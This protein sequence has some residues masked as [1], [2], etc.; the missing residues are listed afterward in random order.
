MLTE[1]ALRVKLESFRNQDNTAEPFHIFILTRSRRAVKQKG[2][3]CMEKKIFGIIYLLIDCTNDF[4]YVG[5]TTRTFEARFNQHKSGKQY[6]DRIIRERGESLI[7]TAILKVCYSRKELD[8]WERHFI[9]SR[10]TKFPNGY[11][12]TDGGEGTSGIERSP[13]YRAKLSAAMTGEKN[14]RY[15][16]KNT[17]EHTARIVAS[18]KGK[19]LSS[20]HC[21]KIKAAL[22]GKP[23]TKERCAHISA[24]KR[25]DSPYKNLIAELD[26]RNLS[27]AAFAKL[28]GLSQGKISLKMNG[29][30]RFTERDRENL[31]KI[32]GK[33]LEY[34]IEGE[35]PPKIKEPVKKKRAPRS[36]S[37]RSK[38]SIA[39]RG[40][41]P[42]K[43]LLAELD[44]RQLSYKA[45]EKLMGVPK[46]SIPRKIRGV[47]NFSDADK[48]KLTEVLG[49]PIEYLLARS[50]G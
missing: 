27:Y 15:G 28:M 31:V 18:V 46:S 14:H 7:E 35:P 50:D 41:S 2:G 10:N 12:M 26:A 48:I 25:N 36:Q 20:E 8:F 11:N 37:E 47:Y 45:L 30:R 40:Y 21:A 42:Y 24:A 6:I 32:F 5:Q 43:N 19:K 17:P 49:K 29:K 44:A 9:R 22:T 1:K 39:Q 16:K 38:R 33:P 13:E 23:F 34:L 3:M 4:E